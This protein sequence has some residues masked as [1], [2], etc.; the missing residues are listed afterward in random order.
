MK[1]KIGTICMFL[2]AALIFAALSLFLLN[3]RQARQAQESADDLL[4]QVEQLVDVPDYS[5]D[6]PDPYDVTMTE[7]E[8]EGY[9]YI[10]CL[11]IPS[12]N[13][14]LPI[15]SNW[16][17]VQL[18]IA[19]CRYSGSSKSDDLVLMAHN[20]KSHFGNLSK[21]EVGDDVLF[22]DMDGAVTQ[23][24]VSAKDILLPTAVEEMIAGE[25]DL[26]L[27]TCTYGG[28][29]RVTIRCDRVKE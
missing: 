8:I 23:Y 13:L 4:Q 18:R 6:L 15:M 7:K 1:H 2:G 12:L 5:Q 19:P 17:Y 26:T 28:R 9:M 10:G 29:S 14:E 11:S 3:E 20:Y 27:F 21:L 22:T 25:Y 24:A 16:S